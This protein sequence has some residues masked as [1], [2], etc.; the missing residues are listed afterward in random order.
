MALYWDEI[1]SSLSLES[2]VTKNAE[3]QSYFFKFHAVGC[4]LMAPW[5]F[6]AVAMKC[7]KTSLLCS[8]GWAGLPRAAAS[9]GHLCQHQDHAQC[10][11]SAANSLPLWASPTACPEAALDT[12]N[13]SL[14][15][16][17]VLFCS[18]QEAEGER[19]L[20]KAGKVTALGD[21]CSSPGHG[22]A[23][24]KLLLQ[25]TGREGM[26][27]FPV[28]SGAF[29][30][31]LISVTLSHQ[32]LRWEGWEWRLAA[33]EIH[34]SCLAHLLISLSIAAG[35]QLCLCGEG[36]QHEAFFSCTDPNNRCNQHL[37]QM[38]LSHFDLHHSVPIHSASLLS[39]TKDRENCKK[40]CSSSSKK[41]H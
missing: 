41:T 13:P 9:P 7:H 28:K 11:A 12:L 5:F 35:P 27:T 6:N 38:F 39:F 2:S 21:K 20:P 37:K 19:A 25:V 16:P 31:H 32:I 29:F 10:W 33:P 3:K 34:V 8:L 4:R 36:I 30:F 14:L 40:P 1:E 15:C 24:T 23:P 22:M 26:H 18:V 17:S